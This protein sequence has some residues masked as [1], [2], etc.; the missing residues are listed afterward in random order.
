MA[1][2]KKSRKVGVIGTPKSTQGAKAQDSRQKQ[3]KRK[4]NP[5]GSRNSDNIAVARAK[6]SSAK[7]NP[8]LGSTKPVD[9]HANAQ[10]T[11]KK[12][13]DPRKELESIEN[14]TRLSMLLDK[15]DQGIKLSKADQT[16]IQEKLSRHALL[17][18]LLGIKNEPLEE[19]VNQ[20]DAEKYGSDTGEDQTLFERLEQG[21]KYL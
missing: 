15:E 6:A 16:Y 14:D 18:E 13:A 4:G 11:Q 10:T 8:K 3:K 5:A 1:R 19:E 20:L 17:C 7:A 12:F 9:L 2:S 21:Q